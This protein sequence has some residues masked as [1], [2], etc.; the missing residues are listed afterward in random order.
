VIFG[1][2]KNCMTKILQLK[3]WQI[4]LILYVPGIA[5]WYGSTTVN[6]GDIKIILSSLVGIWTQSGIALWFWEVGKFLF[7]QLQNAKPRHLL[8]FKASLVVQITIIALGLIFIL[9][10]FIS[11]MILEQIP[12]MSK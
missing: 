6:D 3:H 10:Y 9:L 2:K 4:L 1:S 11:P 7:N 5:F 8:L 12:I